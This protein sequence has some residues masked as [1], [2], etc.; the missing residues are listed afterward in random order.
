[1][2]QSTPLNQRQKQLYI[3]IVVDQKYALRTRTNSN[4]DVSIDLIVILY[5]NYW[6]YRRTHAL[7]LSMKYVTVHPL[8]PRFYYLLV[9]LD[10]LF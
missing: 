7:E 10:Y 5:M 6:K 4:F 2:G 1:M 8:D 9:R 3:K